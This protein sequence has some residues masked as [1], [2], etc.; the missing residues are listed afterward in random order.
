M[1]SYWTTIISYSATKIANIPLFFVQPV[2]Q[3]CFLGIQILD[4]CLQSKGNFVIITVDLW[5][6]RL[7]LLEY[8]IDTSDIH[9][10]LSWRYMWLNYYFLL[11]LKYL[12]RFSQLI[13]NHTRLL[14]NW[15]HFI[16]VL[17]NRFTSSMGF[18]ILVFYNNDNSK[19]H[20]F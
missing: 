18:H 2:C 5:L 14:R 9:R 7:H 12:R 13:E 1:W 8:N 15:C 17:T 11:R 3:L 19:M 4:K 20:Q 10:K 16:V 6:A